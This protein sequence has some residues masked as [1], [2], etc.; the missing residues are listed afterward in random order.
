[1]VHAK[2]L[3]LGE[4][5]SKTVLLCCAPMLLTFSI[6]GVALGVREE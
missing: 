2:V 5:C 4:L 6:V 1:M 3:G